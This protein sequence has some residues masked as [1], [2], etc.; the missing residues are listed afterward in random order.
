[1]QFSGLYGTE[2]TRE[3]GSADTTTLFTTARRKAAINA[4][5]LEWVKRTECLTRQTS[6]A[7]VDEQQEYDLD[8]I[9]NADFGWIATQGVSVKVVTASSTYYVEG[10]DLPMTTVDALT[11]ALPGWRAISAGTPHTAYLRSDG[12]TFNLGL[13]P[14]P[15]I[16][17][18]ETWTALVPYVCVPAD[19]SADA[20]EPF[21]IASNA[22]QRLRFWHRA[23]VHYAAAD[24][25][26]FRK[27]LTRQS[28]QMQLF[29]AEI[30][31]YTA[32]QQPPNGAP[33][34]MAV[35][36]RQTAP[37]RPYNPRT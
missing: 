10:D 22:Q 16:G 8:A 12:G 13:H 28:L 30:A 26:K 29:E 35:I 11:A 2:L 31:K 23:L 25:E 14:A 4:A 1:M 24:L 20:D 17:A 37:R 5:Q 33:M 32:T 6:V 36:Y 19:M 21:T 3:L 9:T 27:D 7:L 15:S 18:G 34:R